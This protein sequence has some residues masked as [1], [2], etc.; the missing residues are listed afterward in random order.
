MTKRMRK[1]QL[2]LIREKVKRAGAGLLAFYMFLT[3]TLI[4]VPTTQTFAL[5]GGPSQPEVQS[6]EPIGTSD[7]VD[8]FSGDM[9][10][11]IPLLDVEGY[12]INLSYSGGPTMDQEAS[13][14]GLGWNINVGTI[15][16]ALRG[17][18]D[19]FKGD[20]VITETNMK[21][22]WTFGI[23]ANAS[24]IEI[25]GK[26][27]GVDS[28]QT[29]DTLV[30]LNFG[31]NVNMGL[32]YNSYNGIGSEFGL[33]FSKSKGFSKLGFEGTASLGLNSSST[34]GLSISPDLG[35][36]G[37]VLKTERLNTELGGKLGL[38]FNSRSGLSSLSVGAN[39]TV[40]VKNKD[41]ENRK[42][43]YNGHG[44]GSASFNLQQPT[45]TP[46]ISHSMR[47][48]AI[49]GRVKT[50]I[51]VWGADAGL[52]LSASYSEQNLAPSEKMKAT[53]SYGYMY[54]EH[55]QGNKDARHD[56][57]RENEGSISP[58]TPNL[59]LTN[60]TYDIYSVSGQG[61]GGSY[62]PYRS[63]VSYVH[64]NTASNTSNSVPITVELGGGSLFHGGSQIGVTNVHSNTGIWNNGN[65]VFPG[66]NQALT[67]LS[68]YNKSNSPDFETVVFREA[69]EM[70][71][72]TDTNFF[73]KWG[74]SS[75]VRLEL[76]EYSK[77]DVSA[78]N[79]ITG[80]YT[81][82]LTI[83]NSYPENGR[84]K[85]NMTIQHL[86]VKEVK[87]GLGITTF[88][89]NS[90]ANTNA[91]DHHMGQ[92][93]SLGTD[94]M[95][96]VY[97]QPAYN[98][99]QEETTFSVGRKL[100]G[101]AHPGNIDYNQGLV[102]Y[103]PNVDNSVN[104]AWGLDNYYQNITTPSFAHSY[105]LT[106]VVSDDYVD[107]DTIK[108][109]SDGDL[110]SY[111]KFS[112]SCINDY[113]WRV[114]VEQNTASYN[115]GLKGNFNDDKASYIYGEKEIHYLNT[116]ETKNFIAIFEL[117]D[118]KDAFGVLGKN[119]GI[120][121]AS[122]L[123]ALKKIS[124][125]VKKEYQTNPSTAVPL[126]Q[127]HFVYDYE[128]CEGIPNSSIGKGKLTLKKVFF[129]Y[130]D[131]KKGKL[132]PYSF[133]Y[134]NNY[135]YNLKAYDRW[136]CYK[137]NTS[138]SIA[139]N[140][141]NLATFEFPYVDQNDSNV[142]DYV[143]GWTLKTIHLPSGGRIDLEF[144]SDDYAYVQNKKAMDM[145]K[146]VNVGMAAEPG[147]NGPGDSQIPDNKVHEY[148]DSNF[149]PN[150]T[151]KPVSDRTPLDLAD[152]DH[153]N[154]YI[155]F[156]KDP[157]IP[158]EL[159]FVGI[160]NL[161]FRCLMEFAAPSNNLPTGRYDFVS[162][163]AEI[164]S[165][166]VDSANSSLGYIKF[167]PVSLS[168][169][170]DE[171]YNPIALAGIN[172]GRL[173]MSRFINEGVP[174]S[175]DP[176]FG[177]QLIASLGQTF[178]NF[179]EG[180]KNPNQVLYDKDLGTRIVLNKSWLR[181]NNVS[182]FKKGG[183]YRVKKVIMNDNW[184]TQTGNAMNHAVYGQEYDYTKKV[185]GK[186]ISSGVASYEPQIG[187][188]ENPWKQPIFFS[189]AV[190]L[191]PDERFYQET[192]IGESFF[193][194]ASVGY[195]HVEV[196][197][198][199]YNNVKKNATGKVVHEFYTAFD[200]PTKTLK[201]DLEHIRHK[202]NPFSLNTLFKIEGKDLYTGSQ[203]FVIETN[204]MHGKPKMQAVYPENS[205]EPITKVEYIY[206]LDPTL[207]NVDLP[208]AFG[209]SNNSF[210]SN[211]LN[212]VVQTILKNGEV[213][214]N[215]IG[216]NFDIIADFNQS[217][218]TITSVSIN[219]NLDVFPI[220]LIPIP[221]PAFWP[222]VEQEYT[223]MRTATLTKVVQRFG[224]LEKTIATDLGSEVETKNLAYDAETGEVLLTETTTNFKDKVY[225]LSFP[226]YWYYDAMGPAYKNIGF[227][228]T[229][230]VNN[231]YFENAQLAKYFVP[232]D[233][234]SL[235]SGSNYKKAWVTEVANN[236]VYFQLENGN[237]PN[238]GSY[239][240]KVLRSGRRN[241][242]S[243]MM[244]SI[245]TRV[246]PL[247]SIKDNV[248][249]Q[250][251]QAS[252]IEFTDEWRTYCN[253]NGVE[254]GSKPSTNPY[255]LGN[256][257]NYRPKVSYLHLSERNQ[258]DVNN[259]TNIR[260]DGFF[261][262]FTPYYRWQGGKWTIDRR[263]WTYTAEVTEFNPFGQEL[264]NR[265]A[266]GRYSSAMFGFNQTLAK[267]VAANARYREIGFTGFEDDNFSECADNHFK[268]DA[269]GSARISSDAHSGKHSV[270][271][272]PNNSARIKRDIAWC[273]QSGC[274]TTIDMTT[275]D[276]F[277]IIT[278]IGASGQSV[279]N[280]E[281]ISG[282]PYIIPTSNGFKVLLSGDFEL[283]FTTVDD[284]GCQA[285]KTLSNTNN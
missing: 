149:D 4:F 18:P 61:V 130:R 1:K 157:A 195:G 78:T 37:Q 175:E 51:E 8:L 115:E 215:T 40:N 28:L 22:N 153:R 106:C 193:P 250:V 128:L 223:C 274:L 254:G 212:N 87:D 226:A 44:K 185:N 109:P 196:K 199:Q 29:I 119:G 155:Y 117:E 270:R 35:F 146:I 140:E 123:K 170:G 244:A 89:N 126:K 71:V 69:N 269:Y 79:K 124:L 151:V 214:Q 33:G 159:Y 257:G 113:K 147:D 187:G 99:K 55:G 104:N 105:L 62:R 276:G 92:I 278:I 101:D 73:A 219:P 260:N 264:E 243:Q 121:T 34:G 156:Q 110:G 27:V 249:Q 21:K 154:R 77:F 280:Y 184:N 189:E 129:T 285:A 259:N 171:K 279:L 57:N 188:D 58:S 83:D 56:F 74:G 135:N 76:K 15:N 284:K 265:D 95:R 240:I 141:A 139:F 181:L 20:S 232:G 2:A 96:Y 210:S 116:V 221:I 54:S 197:N 178:A 225:S 236:K 39:T 23:T 163:Y 100:N 13:W 111:T 204:D 271:V 248:Y 192:P 247:H 252:A 168:D 12:P 267:A 10:Y 38:S 245:T 183:G 30:N 275:Q 213:Q 9:T 191:A 253:C 66:D 91:S 93:I 166:G 203:G 251:L 133:E 150:N 11:N 131:S 216:V 263:D 6:F 207:D 60:Y 177:A 5:T 118:R 228:T 114:P 200:F 63:Q 202:N 7:M 97:G 208:N 82:S 162:G 81:P 273:D 233:E 42:T 120:N 241:M 167:K 172:F 201:T 65:Y 209:V 145:V 3:S 48:F 266:L 198:L 182:G 98:K 283:L 107:V 229:Q 16:R 67:T 230:Q 112:Y 220:G 70:S 148:S 143:A 90:Y 242:Q 194:S 46:T 53:P 64:S 234:V 272:A 132:N 173:Y 45:Y 180:F 190:K 224:I 238:P 134:G 256:K 94:G 136:G 205:N 158:I 152:S 231:G 165:F 19:D 217:D 26:K 84:I 268:F 206:K 176:G 227:E 52:A 80:P 186:P 160:N 138:N 50:S 86:T 43:I 255:F 144:E 235:K 59:A 161:Y 85:R 32:N 222:D 36:S 102:T 174:I 282:D 261:S 179:Y 25:F 24:D 47:S 17:L 237:D 137:P 75:P 262:S 49:T 218:N 88:I 41:K 142:N 277:K 211:V 68:Y 258:S 164:E 246:N 103:T 239:T 169:N 72:D 127:V 122:P 108:G 125:Y 14:V 281:I 31:L